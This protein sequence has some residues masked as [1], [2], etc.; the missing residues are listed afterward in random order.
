MKAWTYLPGKM[1]RKIDIA[2]VRGNLVNVMR[3]GNVQAV[4]SSIATNQAWCES[5]ATTSF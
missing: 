1:A 4:H 3:N 5:R 2:I